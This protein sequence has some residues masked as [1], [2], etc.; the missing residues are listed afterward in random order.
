[1]PK[2]AV[3]PPPAEASNEVVMPARRRS[4][5]PAGK[6]RLVREADACV[7]RGDIEGML[8]REGIYSPHLATWRKAL[9]RHGVEGLAAR[10]PGRKP[11]RDA[12]FLARPQKAR[13]IA[14]CGSER[15]V[16][17]RTPAAIVV[18]VPAVSIGR[19]EGA[20]TTLTL[21]HSARD[22]RM[23]NKVSDQS[24]F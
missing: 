20:G 15:T 5:T 22:C 12:G 17:G 21:S 9:A 6:L 24:A 4:V 7:A 1:M 13:P 19:M 23:V 11:K 14:G 16:V 10:R 3:H 2:P 18:Q 8:R